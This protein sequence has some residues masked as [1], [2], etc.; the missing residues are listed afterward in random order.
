MANMNIIIE[1]K[2]HTIASFNMEREFIWM[3]KWIPASK[4]HYKDDDKI[5]NY[6]YY[7]RL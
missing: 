1:E 5:I 6:Y 7:I 4:M 2:N 3:N